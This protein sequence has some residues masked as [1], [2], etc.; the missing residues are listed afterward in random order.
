MVLNE[1]GGRE[2]PIYPRLSSS[3]AYIIALYRHKNGTIGKVTKLITDYSKEQESSIGTIGKHVTIINTQTVKNVK[4]EDYAI[5]EN[6]LRLEN[7]TICSNQDA[8]LQLRTE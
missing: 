1:T 6:V 2:V 3:L 7:G 4:I 8:L 5:I